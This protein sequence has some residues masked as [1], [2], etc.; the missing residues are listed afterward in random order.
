M[1]Y[2]VHSYTAVPEDPTD[3][4]ASTP[5]NGFDVPAIIRRGSVVG[6]QFHPEKSGAQ[7][8]RLLARFLE[9]D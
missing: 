3:I 8:L 7:G 9:E 1:V 6:Y 4:V 2:F 5:I